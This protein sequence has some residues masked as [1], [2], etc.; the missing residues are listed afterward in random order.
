MLCH[1]GQHQ[2]EM[3]AQ[4]RKRPRE[5]GFQPLASH[6][7]AHT[8]SLSHPGQPSNTTDLLKRQPAQSGV[9]SAPES[10][11]V[12]PVKARPS[13]RASSIAPARNAANEHG[14][15]LPT[16]S[17][18]QDRASSRAPLPAKQRPAQPAFIRIG[19]DKDKDKPRTLHRLG[20]PSSVMSHPGSNRPGLSAAAQTCP[21]TGT[22]LQSR[23]SQQGAAVAAS[24]TSPAASS[25]ALLTTHSATHG[26]S[27][28]VSAAPATQ[29][30]DVAA[31]IAGDC[32]GALQ[33]SSDA[34]QHDTA[35]AA[36][37]APSGAPAC[38]TMPSAAAQQL[39]GVSPT[40]PQAAAVGSALSESAA[41]GSAPLGFAAS[42]AS[43]ASGSA[44]TETLA[45]PGSA[46]MPPAPLLQSRAEAAT[47]LAP[48]PMLP[49][50]R[51][52]RKGPKAAK[53]QEGVKA[54]HS[55][56]ALLGPHDTSVL[57][58]VPASI[59]SAGTCCERINPLRMSVLTCH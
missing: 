9:D 52:K 49:T 14:T 59:L 22:P 51:R 30:A 26:C 44:A 7:P 5:D 47:A 39:G 42:E 17:H 13:G 8:K 40:R 11:S 45:S 46:V 18:A 31:G 35:A 55:W 58:E 53:P 24:A 56:Q 19:D 36:A 33:Q 3:H 12:L 34:R 21:S 25:A 28:Q 38:V 10:R 20:H 2:T 23:I 32:N 37:T 4:S 43:T 15:A 1:R 48:G 27:H 29:A 50:S 16:G 6:S 41:I 54:A 57:P